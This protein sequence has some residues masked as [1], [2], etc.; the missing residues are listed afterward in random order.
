M[1][2]IIT[3]GIILK[4]IDYGEAD[5]ILTLLTPDQGKLHLVARG[6]RRVKSK[7][8][9]GIELFSVSHITFIRGRGELGTL[10]STRLERH[11]G[12]VVKDI[13]RVQLG[14]QVI[15]LLDKATEDEPEPEYFQ[16]L[17]RTFLV[18]DEGT[19]HLELISAWFSAQLLAL[20]GHTPNMQSDTA[21]K[22]LDAAERYNFDIAA[23]S[24]TPSA[25]GRFA[26]DHIKVLR[27]LFNQTEPEVLGQVQGL[28]LL[29]AEIAPLVHAM[30]SSHLPL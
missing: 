17:E 26:A 8:A 2:Q 27:L 6:V 9:G 5:R 25:S 28:N 13:E 15:K 4:R 1:K 21:G 14:Y 24:F 20:G 18:L 23:M 7:L 12:N 10:V 19:M 29:V 22:Q 30:R 16:L 3:T 11:Y